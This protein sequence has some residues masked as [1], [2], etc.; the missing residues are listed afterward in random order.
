M[1]ERALLAFHLVPR[2]RGEQH[3][4]EF[5]LAELEVILTNAGYRV[6]KSGTFHMIAPFT[7][8]LSWRFAERLFRWELR[9][10]WKLGSL[11]YCLAEKPAG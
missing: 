4:Q 7:A 9:H 8:V 1:I 11:L 10:C 3:Q 2:L 5:S 6:L